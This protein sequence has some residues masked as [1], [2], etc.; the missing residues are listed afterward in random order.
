MWVLFF[1]LCSTYILWLFVS[2]A[3]YTVKERRMETVCVYHAG[4][5]TSVMFPVCDSL[6][7]FQSKNVSSYI[8]EGILKKFTV[9]KWILTIKRTHSKQSSNLNY[10]KI[11]WSNH[12]G[13]ILGNRHPP[14]FSQDVYYTSVINLIS[15]DSFFVP[16]AFDEDLNTVCKDD[17]TCPCAEVNFS[18][19]EGNEDGLFTIDPQSGALSISSGAVPQRDRYEITLKASNQLNSINQPESTALVIVD[20]PKYQSEVE[21]PHHIEKRVKF[22]KTES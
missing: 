1:W 8:Q 6:F 2:E 14:K 16:K 22:Q 20:F 19:L 15:G 10:W 21:S 12:Y 4:A 7:Y 9:C 18:I 3:V 11:C 5:A 17:V 13:S